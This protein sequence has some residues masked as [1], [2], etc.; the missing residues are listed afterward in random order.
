MKYVLYVGP[1]HPEADKVSELCP[2]GVHFLQVRNLTEW[3]IIYESTKNVFTLYTDRL[4]VSPSEI[5]LVIW[6]MPQISLGFWEGFFFPFRRS[7]LQ[8]RYDLLL[9][10]C[11]EIPTWL[12][13]YEKV[14]SQK[15]KITGIKLLKEVNLPVVELEVHSNSVEL[16]TNWAWVAIKTFGSNFFDLRSSFLG[17]ILPAVQL[18]IPNFRGIAWYT[19]ILSSKEAKSSLKNSTLPLIFQ[20]AVRDKEA[21]VRILAFTIDGV[22]SVS[23]CKIISG[24]KNQDDVRLGSN[25]TNKISVEPLTLSQEIRDKILLL[26]EKSAMQYAAIDAVLTVDGE[27][28]FIAD[29]NFHGRWLAYDVEEVFSGTLCKWLNTLDRDL[30]R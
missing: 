9:R 24:V 27:L 2:E 23:G 6:R 30:L 22:T 3:K 16:T 14:I 1:D 11:Q 19:K 12:N 20:E 17:V 18:I 28:L 29:L 7:T 21:D 26:L 8:A 4:S 25:G 13:R 10:F 15:D 5:V